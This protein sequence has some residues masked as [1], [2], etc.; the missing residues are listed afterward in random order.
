MVIVYKGVILSGTSGNQ[1]PILNV[2]IRIAK[3]EVARK[4]PKTK[5]PRLNDLS[6]AVIIR[7]LN[8]VGRI[9]TGYPGMK[10]GRQVY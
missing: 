1:G 4:G 5:S 7:N 8:Q 3:R 10:R 6:L 9:S 2:A